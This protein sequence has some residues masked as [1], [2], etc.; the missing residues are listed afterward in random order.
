MKDNNPIFVHSYDSNGTNKN[1][2]GKIPCEIPVQIWYDYPT[3][4]K[5]I[6]RNKTWDILGQVKENTYITKCN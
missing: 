5:K 6:V 1:N 2:T 4:H 3:H